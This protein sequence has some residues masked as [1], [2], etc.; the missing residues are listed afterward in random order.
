MKSGGLWWLRT[1]NLVA[2]SQILVAIWYVLHHLLYVVNF[3]LVANLPTAWKL[4]VASQTILVTLVTASVAILSPDMI[5][6][7]LWIEMPLVGIALPLLTS[8]LHTWVGSLVCHLMLCS[9]HLADNTHQ[10]RM[11]QCHRQPLLSK[12][13][14]LSIEDIGISTVQLNGYS[15]VTY[16]C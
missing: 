3:E 2:N 6:W 15:M 14:D 5:L 7:I 16:T 10:A 8:L 11:H 1:R 4:L 13:D 12:D 9:G